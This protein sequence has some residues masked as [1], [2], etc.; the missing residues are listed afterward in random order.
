[1]P[2]FIAQL[3]LLSGVFAG[4]LMIAELIQTG[5]VRAIQKPSSNKNSD[6]SHRS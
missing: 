5:V 3:L 4:G 1:M 2:A 6:P